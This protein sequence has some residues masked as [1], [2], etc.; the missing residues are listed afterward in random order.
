MTI[1]LRSLLLT[2]VLTLIFGCGGSKVLTVDEVNRLPVGE[3]E[4]Y[5]QQA[6]EKHPENPDNFI[7][8]AKHYLNNNEL[9]KAFIVLREGKN[10]HPSNAAL[11]YMFGQ[12]AIQK[13]EKKAGFAAFK[14]VL[15][16]PQAYDYK[17]D[18]AGYVQS[19]YE[20]LPVFTDPA[21]DAYP[22]FAPDDE[23]VYFQSNRN[24][25][26]DIFQYN[27]INNE[28]KQITFSQ[29]D[30]ELPWISADGKTLY[31]TSNEDDKRPVSYLYK[32]R[33]I[34][35]MDLQDGTVTHL[36]NTLAND[37]LPRSNHK[38]SKIVFVSER[39]DLRDVPIT[40]KQSLVFTMEISGDF[41]MS[42]FE[43][44]G[45]FGNP[46]FSSDDK[47]IFYDVK[48]G[49]TYEIKR[50]SLVSENNVSLIADPSADNVGPYL[51]PDDSS[52]VFFS[53]RDGN[54]EIYR[55]N[56]KDNSQDRLTT[57]PASDLNP[58]YSHDGSKIAFFSDRFGNYDIFIMDLQKETSNMTL[59]EVRAAVDN[60][61]NN[62]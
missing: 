17:N 5:L 8:L 45:I 49:A 38:N 36:T 22:V 20:V 16:S 29:A 55:Y 57:N 41:Q 9:N 33:N 35:A 43:E 6:V 44:E 4:I 31:Y 26:W 30:E 34:Y 10:S 61:V 24:G 14:A 48:R 21:N 1:V 50:Y 15:E 2:A 19:K 40:E 42:L 60:L 12:I 46:I 52:M 47:Y 53:N 62:L 37:W 54:F 7:L 28:L 27:I 3:K 18:I 23:S 25:N 39:K 58:V 11:N 59:D 32:S 13:G 56:F 51:S